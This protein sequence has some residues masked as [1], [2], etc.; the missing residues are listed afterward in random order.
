[1]GNGPLRAK[2]TPSRQL[3]HNYGIPEGLWLLQQQHEQNSRALLHVVLRSSQ[4]V[5]EG[6]KPFDG[7]WVTEPPCCGHVHLMGI[8]PGIWL[9]DMYTLASHRMGIAGNVLWA[10]IL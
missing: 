7:P 8:L 10:F 6:F 3:V 5:A 9:L 2:K 1:M 4:D